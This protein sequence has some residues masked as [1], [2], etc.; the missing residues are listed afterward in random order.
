MKAIAIFSGKG[1]VGKTTVSALL[2]LALSRKHKVALFDMDINFKKSIPTMF[3]KDNKIGNLEIFSVAYNTDRAVY[4][5]KMSSTILHGLAKQVLASDAE[6]CIIDLPPG[7]S[8]SHMEV[9]SKLKPSSFILVVQPNKLSEVDA[10]ESAGFFLS[11]NISIAGVIKNMEGEIFGKE[12]DVNVLN[13]PTLAVIPLSRDI[14]RAGSEGS[15]GQVKNNPFDAICEDLFTK[16]TAVNWSVNERRSWVDETI[17]EEMVEHIIEDRKYLSPRERNLLKFINVRT[18]ELIRHE[19]IKQ[20]VFGDDFLHHNDAN[21]IGR[22][23]SAIDNDGSGM[24]MVIRPP[25]TEVKLFR[26]EIGIASLVSADITKN[27]YYYGVPR[28]KYHT[29]EGDVVLFPHEVSPVSTDELFKIQKRREI[30]LAPNSS[31]PRYIPSVEMMK[32]IDADYGSGIQHWMQE[33][34]KLGIDVPL[35]ISPEEVIER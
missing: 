3:R 5:G 12:A 27:S 11:T 35:F 15:L 18:W 16:A 4:T 23:L 9:C 19:L 17:T 31:N 34:E 25:A 33:Y 32:E 20:D 29:D 21:T 1:G 13:L 2:S 24:F 30:V 14:A 10:I 22:M 6:I 28:V 26:G 8:E 7:A